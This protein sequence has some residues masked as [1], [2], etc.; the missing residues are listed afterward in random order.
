MDH[1]VS[2]TLAF[3]QELGNWARHYDVIRIGIMSLLITIA[4]IIVPGSIWL[5]QRKALSLWLLGFYLVGGLGLTVLSAEYRKL[6]IETS[7]ASSKMRH[8]AVRYAN[9]EKCLEFTN[10]KL[11][12][13][14]AQAYYEE[15]CLE[16]TDCKVPIDKED[17][18]REIVEKAREW[19]FETFWKVLESFWLI[20]TILMGVVMPLGLLYMRWHDRGPY[21]DAH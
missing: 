2:I 17:T 15:F 18:A 3:S 9:E 14:L 7:H 12:K 10:K 21:R 13:K 5:R 6:Y 19:R 4:T 20:A 16:K 8:L 1:P 11:A